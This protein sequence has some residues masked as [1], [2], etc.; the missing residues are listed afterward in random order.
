MVLFATVLHDPPGEL[1]V[2]DGTVVELTF[3]VVEDGVVT[4]EGTVVILVVGAGFVVL[5]VGTGFVV[6]KRKVN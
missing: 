1:V 3:D 6:P 5:V 4:V 2:L